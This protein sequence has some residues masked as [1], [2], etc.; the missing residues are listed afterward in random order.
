VPLRRPGDQEDVGI[1]RL[2]IPEGLMTLFHGGWF[3]AIVRDPGLY[4]F[5]A[6]NGPA[7]DPANAVENERMET[8][9]S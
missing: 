3:D 4:R 6:K 2:H 5:R 1:I 8:V 7:R 9:L